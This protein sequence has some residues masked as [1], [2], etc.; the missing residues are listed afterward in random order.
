MEISF[1]PSLAGAAAVCWPETARIAGAAGYDAVDVPLREVGDAGEV[2]AAAGLAAGPAAQLPIVRRD[3]ATFEEDSARCRGWRR[4]PPSSASD[5]LPL[6]ARVVT[7]PRRTGSRWRSRCSARCTAAARAGTSCSG[8]CATP[9]RW[10]TT[11]GAHGRR[12]RRL[13]LASRERDRR[14]PRGARRPDPPRPP[15]RRAAG[16]ARGDPRPRAAA[17]RRGRRRLRR[18]LRG[19][20]RGRLR[21]C[22]HAGD[23]RLPLRGRPGDV[24]PPRARRDARVLPTG[25]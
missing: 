12:R 24:R 19:P 21:R 22:G 4:S 13:A 6:G 14:R 16:R 5:P 18:L 11:S 25:R 7:R 20:R 17:A 9:P 10:R 1:H 3:E 2:L 15:R 23:P 8:A